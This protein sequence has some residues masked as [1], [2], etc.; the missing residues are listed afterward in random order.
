MNMGVLVR[1]YGHDAQKRRLGKSGTVTIINR[2]KRMRELYR[3]GLTK[4]ISNPPNIA[5]QLYAEEKLRDM[6]PYLSSRNSAS[7]VRFAT[8]DM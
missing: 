1:R 2:T 4:L 6:C 5:V 7:R 8:E 3:N